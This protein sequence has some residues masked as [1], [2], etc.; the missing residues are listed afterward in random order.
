[1][2]LSGRASVTRATE[3]PASERTP[4]SSIG[5]LS[6]RPTSVLPRPALASHHRDREV[7]PPTR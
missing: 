4:A 1:L 7:H 5:R 6:V 3:E 2:R